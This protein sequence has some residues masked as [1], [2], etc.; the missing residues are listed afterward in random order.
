M[1]IYRV[2]DKLQSYVREG[3]WLPFGLRI[4]SEER[5]CE[6]IDK[7][8]ATLPDE[9]GRAK[10]IATNK[11]RMIRDAQERAEQIVYE[12]TSTQA[13]LIDQ[14]DITR[15]AR[16]TAEIV[17]REAEEKAQRIRLGADAYAAQVL[18][19]LESRLATALGSVQK[20][21]E[22]L[23]AQAAARAEAEANAERAQEAAKSGKTRVSPRASKR[24]ESGVD[25]AEIPN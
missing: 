22:A 21:Q 5:L 18:S 17:L 15:Q 12:A 25:F 13:Q 9:V 16:V 1:S 6:Y 14:T 2:I 24:V 10:R 4:I 23:V 8:R 11:D 3:T 7:M 20:G 19:E